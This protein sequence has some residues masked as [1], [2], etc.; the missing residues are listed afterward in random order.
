VANL[1]RYKR[2]GFRPSRDLIVALTADEEGAGPLEWRRLAL[3]EPPGAPDRGHPRQLPHMPDE[4]AQEVEVALH[5]A[6]GDEKVKVSTSSSHR[7]SPMSPMREDVLRATERLTSAFWPGVA[8][9]P[10]MVM[11]G[12]DGRMLRQAGVPTMPRA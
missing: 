5:K 3:E 1:I 2:E 4:T 12:T 6:V 8:T 10:Y 7:A 9:L 11:G